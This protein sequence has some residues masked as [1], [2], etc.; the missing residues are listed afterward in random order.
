[1]TATLPDFFTAAKDLCA[2]QRNSGY[3]QQ[4]SNK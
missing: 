4:V 1:V 2:T 3:T